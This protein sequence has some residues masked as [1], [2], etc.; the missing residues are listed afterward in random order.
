MHVKIIRSDNGKEFTSS[1]MKKFYVDNGIIGETSCVD[2]PQ[3]N[4]RVERK[5]HH[6][7][8]TARALQFQASLPLEF[9]EECALT[10][11]NLINRTPTPMLNGKTSY[12]VLLIT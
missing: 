5:H 11:A 1:P 8:N 9:W 2:T 3:Q 10:A 4:G 7:L 6:I 12:E